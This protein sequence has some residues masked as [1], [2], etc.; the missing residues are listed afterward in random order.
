MG[1]ASM[2][3][4]R[5]VAAVAALLLAAGCGL[6]DGQQRSG[7][8]RAHNLVVENRGDRS[9]SVVVSHGGWDALLDPELGRVPPGARGYFRIRSGHLDV[10]LRARGDSLYHRAGSF[11]FSRSQ[12]APHTVVAAP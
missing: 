6:A 1:M 11:C 3:R 9:V 10:Y 7:A 2:S 8:D 4:A 5:R 12:E